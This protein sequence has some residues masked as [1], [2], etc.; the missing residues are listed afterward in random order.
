MRAATAT[1]IGRR[2][3]VVRKIHLGSSKQLRIADYK[4]S[5]ESPEEKELFFKLYLVYTNGSKTDWAAMT[6]EYNKSAVYS[7]IPNNTNPQILM[8]AERHLQ[9]FEKDF[10]KDLALSESTQIAN[11]AATMQAS[12]NVP[13]DPV[14]PAAQN[15]PPAYQ[16]P[17]GTISC[18][19]PLP[20]TSV[21]LHRQAQALFDVAA[22]KFGHPTMPSFPSSQPSLASQGRKAPRKCPS[23]SD[24]AGCFV[25]RARHCCACFL[26]RLARSA[27]VATQL[28]PCQKAL[29]GKC[30]CALCP[31]N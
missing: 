2:P 23:C 17:A 29:Q 8:K 7:W 26:L 19:I 14:Y 4:R 18:P 3:E 28:Q 9:L 24:M 27:P 22:V 13:A 15:M 10:L 21:G 25:P 31:F 5:V 12:L 6:H 30:S 16:P 1:A 20:P 11:A